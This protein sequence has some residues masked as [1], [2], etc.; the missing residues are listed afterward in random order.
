MGRGCAGGQP[1]RRWIEGTR[2]PIAD[3]PAGGT[4][5]ASSAR[6]PAPP[7]QALRG[8]LPGGRALQLPDAR[9]ASLP[10]GGAAGVPPR[11]DRR[12]L[13][14]HVGN[15]RREGGAR[16]QPSPSLTGSKGHT[17]TVAHGPRQPLGTEQH[18]LLEAAPWSLSF[19]GRVFIPPPLPSPST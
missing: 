14:P 12:Q 7:A 18:P 4:G 2:I 10:G 5:A 11:A 17:S 16:G 9:E 6:L 1:S 15:A 8:Q 3:W 19:H 13:R